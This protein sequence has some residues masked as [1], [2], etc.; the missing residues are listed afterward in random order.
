MGKSVIGWG[1]SME[2]LDDGEE[3]C[4][5]KECGGLDVSVIGVGYEECGVG[6]TA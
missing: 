3:E 1:M 2:G 5:E 6:A 4:G